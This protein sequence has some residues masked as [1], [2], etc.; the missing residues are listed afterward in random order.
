MFCRMEDSFEIEEIVV[1]DSCFLLSVVRCFADRMYRSFEI[2][3]IVV[4]GS[5]L[6]FYCQDS[7]DKPN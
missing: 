1:R 6:S 5:C 7:G 2:K 3:E 4:R